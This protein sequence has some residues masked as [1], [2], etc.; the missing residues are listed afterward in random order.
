MTAII[1]TAMTA[2]GGRDLYTSK[3][4]QDKDVKLMRAGAIL[5]ILI[6]VV[7]IV[8]TIATMMKVREKG[9]RTERTATICALLAVPFMSVRLAFS[10]GSL[11]SGSD[12]VL[13]PMSSDDTPL[14]LH[15]FM[16]I[17]MEYVVILST[18]TVAL[19]ARRI[20]SIGGEIDDLLSDADE[21]RA[22]SQGKRW[23]GT[24]KIPDSDEYESQAESHRPSFVL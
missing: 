24:E 11:F 6:F 17:L 7:Y 16:V 4:H 20:V 22:E 19:T 8:L 1:A 3:D 21:S 15:L 14:W 10:A 2:Y 12:S 23:K 5:F 18:T 13:N 9:H